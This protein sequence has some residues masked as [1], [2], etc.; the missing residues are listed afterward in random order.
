[1]C[2][3]AR[4][5]RG[6]RICKVFKAPVGAG[7][8]RGLLDRLS[9]RVWMPAIGALTRWVI[10]LGLS[11]IWAAV[12]ADPSA[13]RAQAMSPSAQA[14]A[15]LPSREALNPT[16]R[17]PPP[18]PRNH[19]LFVEEPPGPCP[20][21]SS[22]LRFTLKEVVF[23][24]ATALS[25]R[26]LSA[27][28]AG[29]IGQEIP[30]ASI[31]EIRDRAA[32][33]MFRRGILARVEIPAQRISDGR[34]QLEVIEA[35]VVNIRVRGDAGHAQAA[36]ERYLN[37]LRGMAPFDMRKA[38]RYLL[39]A[40][41]I[42][43]VQVRIAVRPSI[44]GE[45]GGVDLDVTVK[46][47]PVDLVANIQ[48]LESAATGRFGGLL[49]LDVNDLTDFGDR[50]TLVAYHTLANDEQTVFQILEEARIGDDGMIAR[51]SFIYGD[52][53][54]GGAVAPLDLKSTSFVA[55]GELAYP[56]VRLRH[57]NLNLAAGFDFVDEATDAIG[58]ALYRDRMRIFYV[59]ADGDDQLDLFSRSIELNG[60][61]SFRHGVEGLGASGAGAPDLTRP[62]GAPDGW[63]LRASGQASTR[64][65][66]PFQISN[67]FQA[68]YSPDIL[69]DYE[70]IALGDLTIGRGYDPATLLGDSG[71]SDSTELRYRTIQVQRLVT[72]QPYVFYDMG[73]I[74]QNGVALVNNRVLTSTG[75]GVV[76]RLAN[77]FNVD[78]AYAIPFQAPAPGLPKPAPRLLVNIT[79]AIF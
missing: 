40:T 45:R 21:S 64:F 78:L 57:R 25:A 63:L 41:D 14:A 9:R 44:T 5:W 7:G 36:V 20:L 62:N 6:L 73:Y 24:G 11:V 18:T 23:H 67:Q 16:A 49:R 55:E 13:A 27:A 34:L 53:L 74:H 77:R 71:F 15:A 54:P 2:G 70:E 66:G 29:L 39:L 19:D 43:G 37:K 76:L 4:V 33:L 38:Q 31:C 56:L 61:L 32:T 59:R 35:H 3:G 10:P 50:T 75:L 48:N 12:I 47:K 51:G 1:M 46:A 72:A 68:Q 79:T 28:Y 30:V 26:Q 42:P 17:V 58:N 60:S 65:F 69:L 52:T 8:A 22:K